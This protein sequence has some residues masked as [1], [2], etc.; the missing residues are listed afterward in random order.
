MKQADENLRYIVGKE[1][2]QWKKVATTQDEAIVRRRRKIFFCRMMENTINAVEKLQKL[3]FI[4]PSILLEMIRNTLI[5]YSQIDLYIRN[6][7]IEILKENMN[8]TSRAVINFLSNPRA[9]IDVNI[10]AGTRGDL[11]WIVGFS[12][13]CLL[14]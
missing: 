8:K 12:S 14:L 6:L 9:I 13:T 11:L 3:E 4:W 2:L 1:A 7:M 5:D 10:K